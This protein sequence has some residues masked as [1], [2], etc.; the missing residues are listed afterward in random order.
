MPPPPQPPVA[1]GGGDPADPQERDHDYRPGSLK[2]KIIGKVLQKRFDPA[3]KS[4]RFDKFT[5]RAKRV[6][7]YAESEARGYSHNYI[8]TE[9]LLLALVREPEGVAGKLLAEFGLDLEAARRQAALI[10]GH[11]RDPVTGP[12]TL[13]PRSKRVVELAVEEARVLKHNYIG[14]EHL[15]LGLIREGEGVGAR[16]IEM[17]GLDLDNVRSAVLE[18]MQRPEGGKRSASRSDSTG[19]GSGTRDT[20]VSCRVGTDDLEAIDVL[21][22][23]GIRSTR[24]DAASWL[25]H[26]GVQANKELFERVRSTVDE[27]RRLREQTQRMADELMRTNPT[28]GNRNDTSGEPRGKPDSNSSGGPDAPAAE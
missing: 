25:I 5:E 8:G 23:A 17:A 6:L 28:D 11:G 19:S 22:E 4:A 14:T 21:I 1:T 2:W 12:I 7:T 10:I 15:L 27:I 9:H 3:G 26:A 24:S 16:L 13:T 20:V 18:V